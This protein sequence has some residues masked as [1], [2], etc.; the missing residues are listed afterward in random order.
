MAQINILHL[1]DLHF[2]KS[3]EK[4]ILII[5]EKENRGRPLI[6]NF[7]SRNKVGPRQ[8]TDMKK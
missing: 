4:D 7:K 8:L 5:K 1:S 6:N 3:N 2:T